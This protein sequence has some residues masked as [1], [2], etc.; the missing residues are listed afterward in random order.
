MNT[1]IT[2]RHDVVTPGRT[3]VVRRY[4]DELASRQPIL[5]GVALV[6]LLA[7][8]PALLAMHFDPRTVND[9]SGWVKPV[10]FLV[11]LSLYYATLAWYFGYLPEMVRCGRLARWIVAMTILVGVA[12]MLWLFAAAAAG[13]PAH[14]NRDA[15][16][17][18][19]AYPLAGVGATILLVGMFVQAR[20]IAA[21]AL[22]TLSHPFRLGI[23]AGTYSACVATLL[24]AAVL[25]AG[26]GHWVGGTPSDADGLFLLGWSRDG[27]DLRVPH[28]WALHG[29][30]IVP[31]LVWLGAD[32]LGWIRGRSGV[33]FIVACYLLWVA[34]TFVQA[35]YGMPFPWG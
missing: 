2:L 19:L 33:L 27:G 18:Q 26:S 21:H 6:M 7:T 5:A 11:S 31:F 17:F 9:I 13:V 23:V 10:K 35:M 34:L 22:P 20:M 28:F 32:R 8:V 24:T 3:N 4:F 12:E 15:S 30:Q 29:H 1:L 25:A 14:F 16:L